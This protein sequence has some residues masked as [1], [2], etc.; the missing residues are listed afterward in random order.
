MILGTADLFAET[1]NMLND[2]K[3]FNF[4]SKNEKIENITEANEL[5]DKCNSY[6][7]FFEDLTKKIK[8]Q[9]KNI[10]NRAHK[11]SLF[12]SFASE[13][14]FNYLDEVKDKDIEYDFTNGKEFLDGISN[15][16]KQNNAIEQATY[17]IKSLSRK[18]SI[19]E[20]LIQ[21]LKTS[22]QHDDNFEIKRMESK[23]FHAIEGEKGNFFSKNLSYI[24]LFIICVILII[25]FLI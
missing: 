1:F 25:Y 23:V 12:F 5:Q 22:N 10:I 14:D 2:I 6:R 9:N 8:A 15:K 20:L 11:S 17:K 18:N 19:Q 16:Q 21:N 4:S 24:V 3:E 7:Q 13:K